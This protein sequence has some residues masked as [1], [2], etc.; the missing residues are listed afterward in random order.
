MAAPLIDF[1]KPANFNAL[2]EVRRTEQ[3]S[4][5]TRLQDSLTSK[6]EKRL[7]IWMAER[8]P[9]WIN[10]D[11]LT[12]LGFVAQVMAG[13]S[14]A[15]ARWNRYWLLAVIGFLALNWLGDSLDGTLAR[16]R[17]QLRPRYGFYVD[18]IVDSFGGLALMAGLGL[19]GYMH[20]YIAVGL[21]VA[22]LLLSIQ[23]YLAT[24]TLGE[25]QLS[26]WNFGPTE[27]RILLAVGNIALLYRPTI[28]HGHYRLFDVGGMVGLIG[29]FAMLIFFTLR[30]TRRLYLQERIQ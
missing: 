25:F 9:S 4:N 20:P 1:R 11:H 26:F 16:V 28:F 2:N 23:S 30:N 14:Y 17:R 10:S 12:L 13:A 6:S 21:L 29:M 3:F 8:T 19:S 5:A 15:L 18:H 7:L 27:L 24:Y 22:F